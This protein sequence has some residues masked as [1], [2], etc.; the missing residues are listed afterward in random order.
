MQAVRVRG[1]EKVRERQREGERESVRES[2]TSTHVSH[3]GMERRKY[4]L[5]TGTEHTHGQG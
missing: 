5:E 1:I 4:G 2:E 3:K